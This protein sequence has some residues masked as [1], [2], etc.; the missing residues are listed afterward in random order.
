MLLPIYAITCAS[1][2]GEKL[3]TKTV[4]KTSL[5]E[6]LNTQNENI[7]DITNEVCDLI[8]EETAK[9]F[10]IENRNSLHVAFNNAEKYFRTDIVTVEYAFY[11]EERK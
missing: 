5:E 4:I 3:T 10:Y 9:S 7:L 1:F 11:L 2:D 8:N 6:A